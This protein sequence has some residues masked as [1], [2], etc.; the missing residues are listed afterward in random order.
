MAKKITG[1]GG[2]LSQ[3]SGIRPPSEEQE[4][5]KTQPEV[6]SP[7]AAA[8]QPEDKLVTVN[9]KIRKSQKEW[10]AAIAAQV[11][12][13]NLDPVPPGDRTYPQHLIGVA[14]DLLAHADVDWS[15]VKNIAQLRKRLNL[16]DL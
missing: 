8:P 3:L 9:L 13:N 7:S 15:E 10:L 11:R 16:L 14:I 12:D 5:E 2:K 1:M 6:T 4:P